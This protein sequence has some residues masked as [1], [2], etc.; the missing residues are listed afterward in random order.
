MP[1][2]RIL[3]RS[4]I[5]DTL[6]AKKNDAYRSSSLALSLYVANIRLLRCTHLAPCKESA[7]PLR[8]LRLAKQKKAAPEL[9]IVLRGG[10]IEKVQSTNPF[11]KA[12]I[13]DYDHPSDSL[14]EA[15]E[16]AARLHM[17]TIY[18]TKE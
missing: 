17:H 11:V 16:I 15:E 13:A 8:Y 6:L 5:R 14:D 1:E 9:V 18:P 2:Q 10:Q 7:Q 3:S 4:C 12:Y